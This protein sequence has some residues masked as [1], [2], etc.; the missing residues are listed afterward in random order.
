MSERR[1]SQEVLF[2]LESMFPTTVGGGAERQAR[3]LA[4]ALVAR[5]VN[6]RIIAPMVPYGPQVEHDS[7]DGVPV[8]R[9]PYPGI[10]MLGGLVMLWRLLVF[11]VANRDS[12]AAIHAH[13]AH[14][15]A[16]VSCLAG[17]LLGKPVVVK[18]TGWLEM[19]RGIL[20]GSAFAIGARVRRTAL[21]K[22]TVFQ[23]TSREICALLKRHG[24]ADTQIDWIPNAVDLKRFS[25]AGA[26]TRTGTADLPPLTFIFVG[27]LVPE[28]WLDGFLSAWERAFSS[29]DRV[30][31]V[32]IGDGE[33]RA[34]L[35]QQV[36]GMGRMH[37]VVFRGGSSRVENDL[38][39]AEIGV[40][41]SAVEGL[42]NA[43][44]EYMAA[45]LPVIGSR[46]SG[47][48]DF[49]IPGATGWLFEA[50]NSQ[51]LCLLLRESASFDRERLQRMGLAGRQRVADLAGIDAVVARLQ[52]H[53]G[54]ADG[55]RKT[56]AAS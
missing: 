52:C 23:A 44:L 6:V 47:T 28:K 56:C 39:A 25:P 12:Y 41:P 54:L 9:I 48:E 13:I 46:I 5:G 1:G 11:L 35:E 29:E 45:G 20:A 51:E 14:N 53:Y 36:E 34:A 7:V 8:W 38:A 10:R 33:L 17:A 21:R 22:A 55:E 26:E 15:M 50:G 18:V 27:R 19:D 42:S 4:R 49:V 40:L 24:F 30:A 3:T 31:L 43:L 2:V 32:I 16:A 37:Q